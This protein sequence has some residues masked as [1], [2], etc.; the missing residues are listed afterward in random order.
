MNNRSKSDLSCKKSYSRYHCL[1]L[2]HRVFLDLFVYATKS[3]LYKNRKFGN[4]CT[5]ICDKYT[6]ANHLCEAK[7]FY[8]A[9]NSVNYSK[10]FSCR[11]YITV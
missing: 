2:K 1:F 10:C 8:I 7:S 6:K 11:T 5:E 3:I 4:F 9:F